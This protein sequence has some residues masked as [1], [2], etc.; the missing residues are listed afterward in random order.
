[1][2]NVE[3]QH[4]DYVT[5]LTSSA[6][7]AALSLLSATTEQKNSALAAIARALDDSADYLKSETCIAGQ[8]RE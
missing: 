4:A 1:M 5:Q 7:R 3:T 8:V 2:S 6:K